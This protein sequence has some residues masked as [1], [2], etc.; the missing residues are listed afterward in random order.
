MVL[1]GY[2]ENVIQLVECFMTQDLE[3]ALKFF[4]T[5]VGINYRFS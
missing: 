4:F 1:S 5:E 3:V 2:F